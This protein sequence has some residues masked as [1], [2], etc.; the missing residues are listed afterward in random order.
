M[1]ATDKLLAKLLMREAGIPTP[2]FHALREES[3][4][5]LGAARRCERIERDLGLPLVVKPARGGS[6]L[7]VKFARDGGQLPGAM[8]GAFS[9]DR[10]VLLERYVRG[11]DLAVSVLEDP[12]AA[13]ARGRSR[14]R[15]SRRC[16]AR[17]SSTTTS[18]ATR[19][20]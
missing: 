11:R 12:G 15:C 7:G 2:P 8:V 3:I 14:C 18:R 1:R 10:T 4:K 20:G 17:R 6:A 9:Y 16:P 19:S 13:R 5:E